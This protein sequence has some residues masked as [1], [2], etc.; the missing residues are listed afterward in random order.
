MSAFLSKIKEL[1]DQLTSY[2]LLSL[3]LVV[4]SALEAFSIIVLS[5]RSPLVIERSDSETLPAKGLGQD[6]TDSEITLFVRRALEQRLNTEGQENG[7]VSESEKEK[8]RIEQE[9]LKKREISQIVVVER[10]EITKDYVRAFVTRLL[11]VGKI[12]SAFP[13]ELELGI[14]RLRRSKA[15]PYGLILTDL[16]SRPNENKGDQ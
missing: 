5:Y 13:A 9:E 15:N 1:S 4:V 12:R 3:V 6:Q 16:K 8:R 10:V 2:K 11:L 7:L 14:E